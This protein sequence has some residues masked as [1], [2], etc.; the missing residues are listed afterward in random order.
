MNADV[1]LSSTTGDREAPRTSSSLARGG[2]ETAS[3]LD[4]VVVTSAS[5]FSLR[6]ASLSRAVEAA[7]DLKWSS[8]QLLNSVQKNF[9]QSL[10]DLDLY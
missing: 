1:G 5:R 6:D 9:S 7:D 2:S 10:I 4:A 8:R 3:R